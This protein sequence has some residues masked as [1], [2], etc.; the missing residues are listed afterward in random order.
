[1]RARHDTV[2][3]A[4]KINRFKS[5]SAQSKVYHQM[6]I[7]SHM[8]MHVGKILTE[9]LDVRFASFYE[10]FKGMCIYESDIT[11]LISKYTHGNDHALKDFLFNRT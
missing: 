3:V 6:D 9:N 11:F 8:I 1:M 2:T 4:N 7:W 10:I 5:Q